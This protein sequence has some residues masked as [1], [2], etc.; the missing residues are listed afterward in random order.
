MS[1]PTQALQVKLLDPRFGDL[2]PLPAYATESSAGMDLRAALEA[3]MTLQ[4]GDAALIPSGIAIHLADP[5]LCAV[6]LPRS[7]LGHRH[8]IVLGNGTGLID[9]DYQGP[10]LISTWNRGREAFTIEPGDR[11]AQLVIL[12]IVRMGL[13]VVDTFVDSARGAG[14][15]GHT[16]VR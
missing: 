8:G 9:A 15:F 6:I 13:Q 16:G 14:G 1:P 5:Q 10:L 11:I 4:P 7:G 12:P 3:P 2:W